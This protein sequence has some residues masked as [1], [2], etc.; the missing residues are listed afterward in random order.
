LTKK[1]G[2]TTSWF[3]VIII[4][5]EF[6]SRGGFVIVV[7]YYGQIVRRTS[8]SRLLRFGRV[9]ITFNNSTPEYNIKLHNYMCVCVCIR[10][11]HNLSRRCFVHLIKLYRQLKPRTWAVSL[12]LA[13]KSYNRYL[14]SYDPRIEDPFN[15]YISHEVEIR[16]IGSVN[17]VFY[18]WSIIY[19]WL[20]LS[21][22]YV[23]YWMRNI[24]V[25]ELKI[26]WFIK[27]VN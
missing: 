8:P 10:T 11:T 9:L 26:L 13:F 12:C 25:V 15:K 1:C 20:L 7:G 18:R 19:C 5:A 16:V 22:T 27:H 14:L 24:W 23:K 2:H 17:D 3:L 6:I 4:D 21:N